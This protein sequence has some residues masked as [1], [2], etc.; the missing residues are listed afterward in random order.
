MPFLA[1]LRAPLGESE[2]TAVVCRSLFSAHCCLGVIK[3]GERHAYI[4]VCVVVGGDAGHVCLALLLLLLLLCVAAYPSSVL[5][6]P[7]PIT[8]A[9]ACVRQRKQASMHASVIDMRQ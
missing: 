6:S 8:H 4:Y 5:H 1:T 3:S 7:V 2:S 9:G